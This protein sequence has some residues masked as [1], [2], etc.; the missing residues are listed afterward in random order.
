MDNPTS[1]FVDTAGRLWVT[2]FINHRVLRF[3]SAAV[4]SNGANADGV[5]GQVNF[6]SNMWATA[7]NRMKNPLAA[8]ADSSGRLWVSDRGN[9]RVLR[10]DNAAS[11]DNGAYADGVLGQ[12]NFSN[13]TPATSASR[14]NGPSGVF[15]DLY[16]RLWVADMINR[17]VLRFD[18][19]AAKG[20]GANA[21][22]VLGQESFSGNLAGCSQVRMNAPGG[23]S[24]D[25]G[26]RLYVVDMN[27][28]RILIFENSAT[29][30]NGSNA[31]NEI[32]QPN[33]STCTANTGGVSAY[34]L[35]TPTLLF[36]DEPTGVLWVA[37]W[38]NN[39]VLMYGSPQFRLFL[40]IVKN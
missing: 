1:V 7:Q 26:G 36:F 3:D 23:L 9:N 4:K 8:V 17:R 21:D 20:Y 38:R 28:S 14:M 33:F 24:V 32:G 30:A 16:G 39:R 22:G 31:N 37:D 35:N 27:N 12:P 2:D 34:S 19:A 13:G 29:L 25:Y 15:L 10:F 18:N 5:L 40:A 6:T 11:E